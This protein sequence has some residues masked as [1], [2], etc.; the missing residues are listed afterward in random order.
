MVKEKEILE[1]LILLAK[2]KKRFSL[3]DK[4]PIEIYSEYRHRLTNIKNF[5]ILILNT[6]CHG[7]GDVVF[8]M[9]LRNYIA[10]WYNADVKIASTQINNFKKLGEK[11]ENLYI[12]KGGKSDQ[13][14]RFKNLNFVDENDNVIDPP[15][16]DL[17]LVAPVQ[18]DFDPDYSDVK[19]LIPYSNYL[20]TY[21]FSEY[22]DS[23]NKGFDFN[24]GVGGERM[25]LLFTKQ[26][27][28][29]RIDKLKNPY[30]V[31]YIFGQDIIGSDKCFISFVE[32]VCKIYYKKYKK[33]D[34]VI[35]PWVEKEL[36]NEES[37]LLNRLLKKVNKYYGNINVKT[38]DELVNLSSG[39]NT[40]TFRAD[41]LPLPYDQMRSLYKYSEREILVTGDQSITD[42]LSCCWKDKLPMYQ[43]VPWKK[44][45][46]KELARYLPQKFIKYITTSCGSLKAI[47]YH[48]NFEKFMK[49]WDFRV[50]AKPN[51]DGI[52][53]F[54][55]DTQKSNLISDIQLAFLKSRSKESFIKKLVELR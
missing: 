2:S 54:I 11:D 55:I 37:S 9:K 38:K 21:F 23:L 31:S 46:G 36:L 4:L 50:L 19:R 53:S 33:F 1:E 30:A 7:F 43:I 6:P 10:D 13:C 5:K 51:L 27:K 41:I 28:S 15:E 42:V 32:M 17:I 24:T 22:N 14:R 39:E 35:V 52:I 18:M 26:Q 48:P 29:K 47:N 16:A 12:L 8:G 44:D 34:I 20:N 25:G 3:R 40:L 49:S 45:F